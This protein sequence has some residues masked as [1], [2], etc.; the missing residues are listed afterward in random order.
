MKL[1]NLTAVRALTKDSPQIETSADYR[2]SSGSFDGI[3][4]GLP[5]VV[6]LG[7]LADPLAAA[8]GADFTALLNDSGLRRSAGG[9]S[10]NIP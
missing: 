2:S 1:H 8:F 6:E 3:A 7:L 4:G 10:S 5:V 9:Y